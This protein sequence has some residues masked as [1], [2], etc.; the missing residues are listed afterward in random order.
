MKM[1][2]PSDL[3]HASIFG[4]GDDD[5]RRQFAMRFESEIAEFELIGFLSQKLSRQFNDMTAPEGP[6]KLLTPKR[7]PDTLGIVI[8][9]DFRGKVLRLWRFVLL[10]SSGAT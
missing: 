5:V 9:P 2:S 10:P 1:G 7:E 8:P 6:V 3:I 4:I